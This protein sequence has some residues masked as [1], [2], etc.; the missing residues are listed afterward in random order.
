MTPKPLV[1][2][3]GSN[4]TFR[5]YTKGSRPSP[6][7]PMPLPA[8]FPPQSCDPPA[9]TT[10]PVKPLPLR[11]GP[12]RSGAPLKSAL[13]VA[14]LLRP[15]QV[16]SGHSSLSAASRPEHTVSPGT[17]PHSGEPVRPGFH[18]VVHSLPAPLLSE[19]V[20]PLFLSGSVA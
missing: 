19:H 16:A 3:S 13:P 6:S 17:H 4:P 9:A 11:E 7:H 10:S 2:H 14:F 15:F 12:A 18:P 8:S 5:T 1:W 20:S